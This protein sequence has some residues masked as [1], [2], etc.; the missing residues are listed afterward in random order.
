MT[1]T[2][3]A[4]A[5]AQRRPIPPGGRHLGLILFALTL[6]GC[7]DLGQLAWMRTLGAPVAWA[8]IVWTVGGVVVGWVIAGLLLWWFRPRRTA[9]TGPIGLI[10]D[11]MAALTLLTIFPCAVAFIA[12]FEG[13]LRASQ[14]QLTDGAFAVQY[15]PTIGDAGADLIGTV[16]LTGDLDSV[17]DDAVAAE[18][19]ALRD[20]FRSGERE[21]EAAQIPALV[22]AIDGGIVREI[23][24]GIQDD[25]VHTVP[26]FDSGARRQLLALFMNQA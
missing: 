24:E 9:P 5:T 25:I 3:T 12:F 16:L 22:A 21:I 20:A 13:T 6:T 17:L 15:F 4:P 2:T 23:A 14:H 8:G 7:S 10:T 26:G 1:S 19:R 18:S 11:S